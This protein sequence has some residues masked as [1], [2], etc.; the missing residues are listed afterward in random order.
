M[1]AAASVTF[2]LWAWFVFTRLVLAPLFLDL[3]VFHQ[4]ARMISFKEVLWLSG[5]WIAVIFG[6][7]V[8]FSG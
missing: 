4:S 8:W 7:F 5:F 3:F 1:S 6:A 2:P